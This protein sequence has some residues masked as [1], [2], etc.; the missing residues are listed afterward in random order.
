MLLP[1]VEDACDRDR[2]VPVECLIDVPEPARS[3]ICL[4][5]A[6]GSAGSCLDLPELLS[7]AGIDPSFMGQAPGQLHPL[8]LGCDRSR[9]DGG[10][11]R[12]DFFDVGLDACREIVARH[13]RE[14]TPEPLRVGGGEDAGREARTSCL[15]DYFRS[16]CFWASTA[17]GHAP[18]R[19]RLGNLEV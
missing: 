8:S 15:G 14:L 18:G 10:H 17:G 5:V 6:G 9:R 7:L 3:V 12:L 11:G 13:G 4:I 2:G 16:K 1:H 19:G